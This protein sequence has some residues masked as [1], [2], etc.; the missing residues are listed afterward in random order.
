MRRAILLA[1]LSC[2]AAADVSAVKNATLRYLSGGVVP[3]LNGSTPGMVPKVG[4]NTL[5]IED[6]TIVVVNDTLHMFPTEM[7]CGWTKTRVVHFTA[8]M[9]DRLNWTFAGGITPHGHG[10]CDVDDHHAKLWS[11]SPQWQAP[12][13]DEPAGRWF[14]SVVGYN[15]DCKNKEGG[16]DGRILMFRSKV[17]GWGGIDGPY[18]EV[19]EVLKADGLVP[20]AGAQ[21]WEASLYRGF[22]S[23][24]SSFA[25]SIMS[26]PRRRTGA[27]RG[28]SP[29]R[30]RRAATTAPS[31][32][33]SSRTPSARS[34][35]RTA[36][37]SRRIRRS[38]S[39]R[40]TGAAGTRASVTRTTASS[41]PGSAR[42][43]AIRGPSGTGPTAARRTLS[44]SNLDRASTF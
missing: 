24:P 29:A 39:G 20:M 27:T 14:M 26:A 40:S 15:E 37:R 30:S 44:S 34:R 21:A 25:R 38:G 9:S 31:P 19:E 22:D 5:G 10:I 6:G 41:A 42:R 4:N 17:A 32:S 7:S 35:P 18:D 8:P 13:P 28:A 11:G 3:I 16:T 43:P 33:A 23:F 36:A 2:R 12:R 1:L